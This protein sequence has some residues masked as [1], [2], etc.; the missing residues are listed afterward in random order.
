MKMRNTPAA[1][2]FAKDALSV[3]DASNGCGIA[4]SLYEIMCE[5]K[6][7]P[8]STG[9]DWVSQNP[10]VICFLDKLCSLA[11]C[12]AQSDK[13]REPIQKAF[14]LCEQ[15]AAGKDIEF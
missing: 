13:D 12:Q 15:L 8:D 11:Y 5:L 9:T 1:M 3:Q 14:Q 4:N 10:I 6:S 7:H 2:M